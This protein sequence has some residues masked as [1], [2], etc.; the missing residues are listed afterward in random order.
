MAA[1]SPAG[2]TRARGATLATGAKSGSGWQVSAQPKE[3]ED[4]AMAEA[5]Q[6]DQLMEAVLMSIKYP[7]K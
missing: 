3:V 6:I 1:Q 7:A 2:A 4:D 5:A